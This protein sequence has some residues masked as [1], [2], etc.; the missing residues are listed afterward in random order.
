MVAGKLKKRKEREAEKLKKQ[1]QQEEFKSKVKESTEGYDSDVMV[2]DGEKTNKPSESG[3]AKTSEEDQKKSTIV[4]EDDEDDVDI[5][6]IVLPG[7]PT[8]ALINVTE[9]LL[10]R[11]NYPKLTKPYSKLDGLLEKRTR[12]AAYELNQKKTILQVLNKFRS[13]QTDRQKLHVLEEKAAKLDKQAEEEKKKIAQ[14]S[15]VVCYS[16]LCRGDS[17]CHYLACYSATCSGSLGK[18]A[19]SSVTVKTEPEELKDNEVKVELPNGDVFDE[20]S[21]DGDDKTVESKSKASAENSDDDDND[22]EDEDID[23]VG[24]SPEKK[25]KEETD[26]S[27]KSQD[28]DDKH[29]FQNTF[30]SFLTKK[31]DVSAKNTPVKEKKENLK[32]EKPSKEEGDNESDL[33]TTT[34]R[35]LKVESTSVPQSKTKADGPSVKNVVITERSQTEALSKAGTML[36]SLIKGSTVSLNQ[37]QVDE[38]TAKLSVVGNT[39][40]MVSLARMMKASRANKLKAA[41][42]TAIPTCQKFKTKS[43]KISIFVI[44]QD[45]LRS[46]SRRAGMREAKGF[47]YNCKMTNVNWMYPCPR[48]L[49]KTSW[50]YRTQT[51]KSLAAIGLQLRVLWSCIRWDDL[52]AKPPA[53]GTNTITTETEIITTEVLKKRNTGP[54]NIRTQ[55]L[56]RKLI[57]PIGLPSQPKGDLI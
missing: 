48:P 57:I 27:S 47:N 15:F 54:G 37:D 56:V 11:T 45:D 1:Q 25:K 18:A 13:Q 21:N 35:V 28:D 41:K 20:S 55:Y 3:D 40:Y 7:P 22:D 52:S 6:N 51:L 17:K 33:P 50:R 12:L 38:M 2:V 9:G 44:D 43:K 53:G 5:D 16:P 42:K 10:K 39:K 26:S 8:E 49:F 31:E 34:T 36:S 24:L 19:K 4:I 30:M 32:Q 23:P 46:L 14:K 29:S